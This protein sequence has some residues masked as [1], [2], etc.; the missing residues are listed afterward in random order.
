MPPPKLSVS[1]RIVERLICVFAATVLAA[2][3][4][5]GAATSPDRPDIVVQD[6]EGANYGDWKATGG[7]FG[8]GPAH[9]AL[10]NQMPV[11]GFLGGGFASSY[12]GGDVSAGAL[13]SPAFQVERNRIQF[14]IGGGGW[15][16]KTCLNLLCEGKIIRTATGSNTQPGGS[17]HLDW[18][19]WDVSDLAGK[20]VVLEIVDSATAGWGHISVDQIIQTDRTKTGATLADVSLPF[21]AQKRYLNLPVKNGAVSRRLSL[22]VEGKSERTF[23]IELAND[24]PDWWA[25][26]DISGFKGES[27]VLQA[28]KLPDNSK[29]LELI[30]QSD[31][32]EGAAD[33]YREALRPQ[34]H[35]SPRRGWNNDA[36]GLV[37]YR[38][39]YHLFYQHNPYGWNWGNMHWGHATSHDLVHWTEQAEAIYPGDLGTI[40]SGSAVVDWH[41]TS[42]F[43]M[44]GQPPLVLTY[45]AAGDHF[46]QCVAYS[47][48][49][50]HSFVKFAGNP[51]IPQI[52]AENRDPK[53]FWDEPLKKWG[54]VLW[55]ERDG[56]NTIQF[57]TSPNL[58]DWTQAGR[59]DDFFECPDF[60]ELPVDGNP[61]NKKW[62][63]TAASSDY[64]VGSF[65][66]LKFSA[67]TAKLPGHCGGGSYAAQTYS[68]IPA[69]DGRRIQI[70]WLRASSPGMPFNQ[71]LTLPHELRLL[72]TAAGPR[73]TFTPVRELQSLRVHTHEFGPLKLGPVSANPLSDLKVELVELRA[74][75]A[76][77]EAKELV[78][79]Y[80]V[81]G[82]GYTFSH[83]KG[84]HKLFVLTNAGQIRFD[85]VP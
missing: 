28:D 45:T 31:Q 30:N 63:L 6:F 15:V 5:C 39:E 50:G 80:L 18:Q 79:Y 13:T 17:E 75:F 84:S 83:K 11:D 4:L 2:T 72:Q 42:G 20:N 10:P 49:G 27:A 56:H 81:S 26:L 32:I 3:G 23:D 33:L 78:F 59:A 38:G 85:P 1:S 44:H 22:I 67:E 25:F 73:L 55:V 47:S 52:T 8:S 69:N 76:P 54:M 34:F 53:V 71:C 46:S 64:E 77:G 9:G 7:A 61:A 65:D 43:G 24:K 37:F 16:G 40:Y 35:Y 74:T 68:D 41:N 58:K 70:G 48:D 60:F 36:N 62:V 82:I 14:L 51:V 12:H 21:T 66:G 57:L 19:A 29:A